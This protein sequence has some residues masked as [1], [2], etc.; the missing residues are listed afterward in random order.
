M[1]SQVENPPK[2]P[3]SVCP[4]SASLLDRLFH[5]RDRGS[6]FWTEIL[7]GATTFSTLSYVLVVHPLM[8]SEAG[9]DRGALISVTALAAA[10]FSVV[11]G[12]RTNYPLAMAPGMG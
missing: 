12:L 5:Y 9:M 8:L 7:G 4:Q 2:V 10:I 1:N 6:T 11:M 3:R